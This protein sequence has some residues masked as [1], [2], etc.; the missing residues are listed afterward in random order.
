MFKAHWQKPRDEKITYKLKKRN[1]ATILFHRLN[2]LNVSVQSLNE[3][4]WVFFSLFVK[5]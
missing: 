3:K 5:T 2:K 4:K 1:P